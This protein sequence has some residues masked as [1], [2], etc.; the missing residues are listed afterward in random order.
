MTV[1]L[2]QLIL[3]L[4][5]ALLTSVATQA[6]TVTTIK[7]DQLQELR[8]APHDTLYVVNFWATW[9][10]PCI[11]EMP[12]FEAA[13]AQ[14]KD[15]PVRVILV[16]MDAVQDKEKRVL[17]F[18]QKRKLQSRLYLLDEP[19][20]NTW[21]DRIEPKWSGAIPATMFFNNKRGQY[22]FIEREIS[23]KELQELITK[24]K[25]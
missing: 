7:F 13:H 5:I 11:K 25:P 23:E 3:L 18:V 4:T 19:D 14:Y 6:Q 9:C 2:K 15:Q 16:S 12:Y 22:E 17:P 24:Y 20:G 8:Q 1:Y 10:K 21:I